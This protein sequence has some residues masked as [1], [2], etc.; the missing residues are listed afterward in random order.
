MSSHLDYNPTDIL[1]RGVQHPNPMFTYG[2][3]F[4]PRRLK[5]AFTHAEWLYTSHPIIY[6]ALSKLALYP[7]TDIVY[8]DD[9]QKLRDQYRR[10]LEDTLDI[11]PKLVTL[12]INR[13][14]Y[15][16]TFISIY[17]PFRRSLKCPDCGTSRLIKTVDYKFSVKD[18]SFTY[19]CDKCNKIVKGQV[20]D[21]KLRLASAIKIIFWPPQNIDIDQNPISGDTN[22]YYTIPDQI[23]QRVING[24][25]TVIN[26]MPMP[27]LQA[28]AEKKLFRFAK[29]KILHMRNESLAGVDTAWG[30]PPLVSVLQHFFYL[31]TLRKA[32]EAISLEHITPFRVMHPSQ[33]SANADPTT[34][35][36][37]ANWVN[38]LKMNLKAWRR[39]P[40]HIMFSPIPV[41]VTNVGGQGR[42]LMVTGEITEAENA[43]IAGLGIPREFIYGGLSATGSGVTLRMIENQLL[44]ASSEL[45]DAMQ[46]IADS[47]GK[48]L[49]WQKI[50]LDLEEPKLVDD[51]QQKMMLLQANGA[52]GNQLFSNTSLASIFGRDLDKER[53]LRM[54]ETLEEAKFQQKLQIKMQEMQNTLSDRARNA[55]QSGQ[56]QAYDQQA[57]I[58]QADAI[59]QQL[60]SIDPGT[61]KSMLHSLQV[62]DMVMYSVVVQ[63][64]EEAQT[65][66]EAQVRV[67]MAQ[68]AQGAPAGGTAPM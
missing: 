23:N 62:E 29:G 65:Q 16:N 3:S 28:I 27:F 24:D 52:T 32:N 9:S 10:L 39:D 7:V 41:G 67:Q 58:A 17:F 5:T 61:R 19:T 44:N 8:K 64:L 47:C 13:Q 60:I 33:S 1:S 4:S 15:G 20:E 49:G 43:I 66:Q 31:N 50:K 12:G 18:L 26:T 68:G 25:K 21:K 45:I 54:Q 40:L 6:A 57:I 46:W 37:L 30:I 53:E 56:A 36:S 34:T 11:K 48:Y 55:A 42:A 2:S 35:I 14:V 59:V 38:E 63:R 22:Y 51:V